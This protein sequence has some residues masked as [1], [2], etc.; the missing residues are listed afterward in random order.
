MDAILEFVTCADKGD[1]KAKARQ[2]DFPRI[3]SY[4]V[5]TGITNEQMTYDYDTMT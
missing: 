3:H 4:L 5:R 2:D 1:N